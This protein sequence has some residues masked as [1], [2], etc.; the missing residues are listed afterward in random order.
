MILD[1]FY[2]VENDRF[3]HVEEDNGEYFVSMLYNGT[4]TVIGAI[5][6]GKDHEFS[7][8]EILESFIER[9][10][11]KYSPE[12]L[13]KEVQNTVEQEEIEDFVFSA[14]DC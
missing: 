3:F 4:F 2:D 6:L 13:E 10:N 11:E 1:V 9:L 8:K 14:G 5:K 12:E 7:K